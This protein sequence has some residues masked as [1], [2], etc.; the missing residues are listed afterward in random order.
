[1]FTFSCHSDMALDCLA[2]G[3]YKIPQGE[4]TYKAISEALEHGYMSIDTAR[5]Y[6]NE[7]DVGK[8]IQKTTKKIHLTTK[9]GNKNN[10][11]AYQKTLDMGRESRDLL[12]VESIDLLLLHWPSPEE[13]N[14]L[15]N[16]EALEQLKDEGTAKY[17]GVSNFDITH[18]QLLEQKGF[19]RPVSN[20]IEINPLR[21]QEKVRGYCQ[22]KGILIEAWRALLN[23]NLHMVSEIE[24]MAKKYNKTIAQVCIKWAVSNGIRVITKSVHTSRMKENIEIFDFDLTS[25]EIDTI[26]SLNKE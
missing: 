15:E 23:G 1:M 2:F 6:E 19:S 12:G 8:A 24:T 9:I 7:S 18:L 26:D 13:N 4:K 20:Q 11:L 14:I 25:H 5:Y 21:T 22:N 3:T 17:I 16:W 10:T